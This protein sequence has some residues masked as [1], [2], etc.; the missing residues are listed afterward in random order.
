MCPPGYGYPGPEIECLN[1]LLRSEVAAAAAYSQALLRFDGHTCQ[2]ELRRLCEEHQ[3]AANVLR[4]HI[5]NLGGEPDA[6][7]GPSEAYGGPL[8]AAGPE[9]LLGALRQGEERG[10][11]GYE[12]FLQAEEMP[13]ECRFAVRGDL[14]PRCH[15]HI[16]TLTGLLGGPKPKG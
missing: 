16:S 3:A 1:A 15:E 9:A 8:S 4:D 14:L 13:Q 2:A 10:L 12:A 11:A 7:F 5:H 6:G